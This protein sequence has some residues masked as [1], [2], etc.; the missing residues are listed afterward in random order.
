MK[1]IL[2]RDVNV[3]GV[4][5]PCGTD[6]STL[7]EGNQRSVIDSGW[8]TEVDS[9][10]VTSYD[11][12]T[13]DDGESAPAGQESTSEPTDESSDGPV[14]TVADQPAIEQPV[15]QAVEAAPAKPADTRPLSEL[16]ID[17]AKLELLAANDPAIVT[18]QQALDF[19]EVNKTFRTIAGFGKTAD[20]DLR[21]KL[22]VL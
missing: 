6:V 3:C 2:N 20:Q 21:R 13:D 10:S 1:R 4:I 15:E 7:P 8:T 12:P 17:A 16:G 5:H 22:G 18:V 11:G 19:L 9:D 14:E